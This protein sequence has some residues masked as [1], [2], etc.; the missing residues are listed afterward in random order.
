MDRKL[1][2]R[3]QQISHRV[4]RDQTEVAKSFLGG[5]QKH[6]ASRGHRADLKIATK[7]RDTQGSFKASVKFD[8][9][10]GYPTEDDLITL[11]A[12]AYPTHDIDWDLAEVDMDL[13]LVLLQLEPSVEVVPVESINQIP[14]EF[15]SIGSGLYKR[16]RDASGN[17]NEIWTLSKSTDG[18]ML[19]RNP[20]DLEVNA[21]D[22]SGFRAGD[23]VNTPY[24]PGRIQR[25]DEV[26]NAIVTVGSQKRLVAAGD[27]T[28]YEVNKEKKKLEDYYAEAYGDREFAK[29][30]VE[31]FFSNK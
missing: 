24:G 13:G 7:A 27:M 2:K 4:N 16:A 30:L 31:D 21:E 28:P 20:D 12:Q 11:V 6:L 10:L 15:K 26:G 9:S 22:E 25:F 29:G 18:L 5:L 19:Y 3:L 1:M 8:A 14:P 17:V 23:V